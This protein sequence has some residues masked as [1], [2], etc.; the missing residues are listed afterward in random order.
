MNVQMVEAC[1]ILTAALCV[2]L[3]G[4]ALVSINHQYKDRRPP[5]EAVAVALAL[6]FCAL[7]VMRFTLLLVLHSQ[8]VANALAT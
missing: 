6:F 1:A 3:I 7:Q 2:L 4:Y 8:E 5:I